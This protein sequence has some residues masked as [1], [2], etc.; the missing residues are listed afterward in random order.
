[1]KA[2]RAALINRGVGLV[3]GDKL[4]PDSQHHAPTLDPAHR[5]APMPF[6][7]ES[8]LGQ[9]RS[10]I[11]PG[12]GDVHQGEYGLQ[13]VTKATKS[14]PSG[15]GKE[16]LTANH[17][18]HA[19]RLRINRSKQSERRWEPRKLAGLCCLSY[20]LLI[21]LGRSQR[22]VNPPGSGS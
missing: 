8:D 9:R 13:K 16:R 1:M 19:K 12:S 5:I 20:L 2:D 14:L 6:R 4:R 7:G 21:P 15:L 11:G 10:V 22:C 3:A 18:N 17:A